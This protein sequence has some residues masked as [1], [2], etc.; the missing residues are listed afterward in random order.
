MAEIT[1]DSDPLRGQPEHAAYLDGDVPLGSSLQERI[2]R[3]FLEGAHNGTLGMASICH[4]LRVLGCRYPVEDVARVVDRMVEFGQLMVVEG[5]YRLPVPESPEDLLWLSI[6][7]MFSGAMPPGILAVPGILAQIRRAGWPGDEAELVSALGSWV[8]E[9]RLVEVEAH[10]YRLPVPVIPTGSLENRIM[11]LLDRSA[12][13]VMTADE[14]RAALGTSVA[15]AL[16]NLFWAGLVERVPRVGG[17]YRPIAR[18]NLPPL[19]TR[20]IQIFHSQPPNLS[21]ANL[22]FHLRSEGRE[23]TLEDVTPVLVRLAETGQLVETEAGLWQLPQPEV[24]HTDDSLENRILTLFG[25]APAAGT[26]ALGQ[27]REGLTQLGWLHPSTAMERRMLLALAGLVADGRLIEVLGVGY[28]LPRAVTFEAV[29]GLAQEVTGD[30][31]YPMLMTFVRMLLERG[32]YTRA[33]ILDMVRRLTPNVEAQHLDAA[34][35]LVLQD[36]QFVGRPE[37]GSIR[38]ELRPTYLALYGSTTRVSDH[39]ETIFPGVTLGEAARG[40]RPNPAAPPG[41][42]IDIETGTFP[43]DAMAEDLRAMHGIDVTPSPET[44]TAV[45][46]DLRAGGL[47]AEGSGYATLGSE[48]RGLVWGPGFAEFLTVAEINSRLAGRRFWP[49][50]RVDEALESGFR[51]GILE[52]VVQGGVVVG[53][54]PIIAEDRRPTAWER[55][56]GDSDL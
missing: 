5:G 55:L 41:D 37:N 32:R 35:A 53:Y 36:P 4:Y 33:A 11:A 2:E 18:T 45:V 23:V 10:G 27:I 1:A 52:R 46:R 7:P 51:S 24:D 54:R 3:V 44:L 6:R 19:A 38:W 40:W 47:T 28:R 43:R 22:L 16:D 25:N 12:P 20:I 34:L 42:Y 48:L 56:A 21:V 30:G 9:G 39:L 14:L 17:G 31:P 8:S 15:R 29:A 26:M 13:A 49:S 50:A